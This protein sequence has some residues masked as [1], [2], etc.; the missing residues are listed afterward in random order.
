M[1]ANPVCASFFL[2]LSSCMFSRCCGLVSLSRFSCIL[3]TTEFYVILYSFLEAS[4][5]Y[6][7][8]LALAIAFIGVLQQLGVHVAF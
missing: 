8:A 2:P 4:L 1:S 5:V 7:V 3:F 6:G